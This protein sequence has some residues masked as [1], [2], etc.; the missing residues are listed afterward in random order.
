M[1]QPT[2][3]ELTGTVTVFVLGVVVGAAAAALMGSEHRKIL[4]DKARRKVDEFTRGRTIEDVSGSVRKG[5]RDVLI[6]INEAGRM[7]GVSGRPGP[8]RLNERSDD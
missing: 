8:R 1:Q 6:D 2:S 4:A 5:V 3:D 7:A